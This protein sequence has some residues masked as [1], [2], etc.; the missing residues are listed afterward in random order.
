[1]RITIFAETIPRHK[2]CF[3]LKLCCRSGCT[4][5]SRASR[6]RATGPRTRSA[7]SRRC[8]MLRRRYLAYNL[9]DGLYRLRRAEVQV[10]IALRM[11]V[12]CYNFAGTLQP[13]PRTESAYVLPD[14]RR[15]DAVPHVLAQLSAG[16]GRPSRV[17]APNAPR[18]EL[19]TR[20]T[21]Q[22][23]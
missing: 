2:C 6:S 23:R 14:A 5:T 16:R 8:P 18:A 17:A 22:A 7:P 19:M 20:G 3:D 10:G 4:S 13:A 11:G 9:F 1:M 12:D 21:Q 15:A